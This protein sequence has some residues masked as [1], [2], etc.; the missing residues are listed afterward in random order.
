ML[1]NFFCLTVY[2]SVLFLAHAKKMDS[3]FKKTQHQQQASQAPATVTPST[4]SKKRTLS[5]QFLQPYEDES[6]IMQ[7]DAGAPQDLN[8]SLKNL[9][10]VDDV[11]AMSPPAIVPSNRPTKAKEDPA[12][13]KL[14]TRKSSGLYKFFINHVETLSKDATPSKDES[15]DDWV[16]TPST[17]QNNKQNQVK[18]IEKLTVPW[19]FCF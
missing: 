15:V 2:F 18:M 4:P 9:L 10:S 17:V 5:Q 11:L 6:D 7:Q 13:K 19:H 3:L 8:S 12:A 16:L 14:A 1:V